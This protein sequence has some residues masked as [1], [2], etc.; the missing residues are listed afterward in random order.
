ML[1]IGPYPILGR[2]GRGG[3]ADILL[4]RGLDGGRCVIKRLHDHLA[5]D[6][7]FVRMFLDEARAMSLLA[8]PHIVRVFDLGEDGATCYAAMEL[9]DGPSLAAVDKLLREAGRCMP[10]AVLI[11]IGA[12]IAEA[13]AFVHA[14]VDPSSGDA[15]ML[16]HR[17]V[18]APNI[19]ISRDG[20]VKLA[21]F[22]L[23]R[24]PRARALG[25]LS[26]ETTATGTR[27]G[28]R[29]VMS[30]E[31][32]RGHTVDARSDLFSLAVVLWESLAGQKLWSAEGVLALAD[33]ILHAQAPQ[34]GRSDV[35]PALAALLAAM[36]EKSPEQRPQSATEVFQQLRGLSH[37]MDA[38]PQ[39]TAALVRTLGLPSLAS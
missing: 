38:S 37:D 10:P 16:V 12:A 23:V 13:L 4:A 18:A 7:R 1:R 33:A 15:L 9:V 8:H 6:E 25:I 39:A 2:I 30:P 26:S 28:R 14:A 32:V 20:D 5:S 31:Q 3:S 24:S 27:K 35:P 22:G 21:D 17:D 34:V 36:L 29:S 11:A 19:L